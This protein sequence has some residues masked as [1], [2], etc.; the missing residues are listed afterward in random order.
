M[1]GY[2]F[3]LGFIALGVANALLGHR[4]RRLRGATT[5]AFFA[6]FPVL[7]GF[8]IA[9]G[10][11]VAAVILFSAS[12]ALMAAYWLLVRKRRR[13]EQKAVDK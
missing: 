5:I 12:A 13:I 6:L 11:T 10:D 9:R 3:I 8:A 4:F 1:L 2:W 7:G